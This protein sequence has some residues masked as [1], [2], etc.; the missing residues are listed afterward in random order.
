MH[1][2][3]E[4]KTDF[5]NLIEK[6]FAIDNQSGNPSI[7]TITIQVTED[8]PLVCSYCYESNKQQNYMS[9]E[10]GKSIIDLLFVIEQDNNNN[11]ISESTQG[12]ILEFIGGEPFLNIEVITYIC[13]YF[14]HQCILRHHRWLLYSRFSI[15]SNGVLYFD[16]KVQVFL[17]KYKYFVSLNI[18]IDGPQSIHD[19][20]RIFPDKTGSFAMANKAEQ[21]YM[22]NSPN[23]PY[24]SKATISPDTLP[25]IEK[26][27]EYFIDNGKQAIYINPIYEHEW[28]ISQAQLYYKQLKKIADFLLTSQQ[29]KSIYISLFNNKSFYP[30]TDDDLECYCGGAGKMLAFDPNGIAYPCLRFMPS[31]LGTELSPVVIGNNEG[32][33]NTPETI[34]TKQQLN[35][36]NRRAKN[37]DECFYCPIAHGCGDCEAWNYQSANGQ[38]NIKNKNICWMH[39]ARALAN[40]Y[41]WNKYYQQNNIN[42]TMPIYIEEEIALQIVS[43]D[44]WEMLC[45]LLKK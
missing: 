26:I 2:F 33:Y 29:Q 39:R 3:N 32:I 42:E 1:L 19:T 27:V 14:F 18:S 16:P 34:Q 23:A 20:C 7:R 40:Y 6:F 24:N 21:D 36:I 10:I 38:F 12:L 41:Y 35:S 5:N 11:F 4:N 13:D 15:S 30:L 44:E 9:K 22:L 31:S 37:D 25:E 45:N 43:Q 17:N 28:T 8:C